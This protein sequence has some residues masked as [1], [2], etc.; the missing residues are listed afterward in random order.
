MSSKGFLYHKIYIIIGNAF[1]SVKS[2]ESNYLLNNSYMNPV[3]SSYIWKLEVSVLCFKQQ[4]EKEAGLEISPP[5][6]V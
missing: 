2:E 4:G 6:A 1:S 3:Q 5:Q